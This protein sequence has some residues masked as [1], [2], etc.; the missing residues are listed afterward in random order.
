MAPR[1]GVQ[2]ASGLEVGRAA[3]PAFRG[4][5]SPLSQPPSKGPCSPPP[6]L[7][8]AGGDQGGHQKWTVLLL[9]PSSLKSPG[10]RVGTL[11]P[12]SPCRPEGD[13]PPHSPPSRL[14]PLFGGIGRALGL[15]QAPLPLQDPRPRPPFKS[16]PRQGAGA[17][18][19]RCWRG[20]RAAERELE[21]LALCACH[22]AVPGDTPVPPAWS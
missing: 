5:S 1:A 13:T 21:W 15:R 22:T 16:D 18:A 19:A 8:G 14:V 11:N 6:P 20:S 7:R 12:S 10:C 17:K 2:K 4:P 3:A 9:G